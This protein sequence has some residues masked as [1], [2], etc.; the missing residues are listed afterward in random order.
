MKKFLMYVI[1]Y[2]LLAVFTAAAIFSPEG[3]GYTIEGAPWLPKLANIVG[4]ITT[5]LSIIMMLVGVISAAV[6]FGV[7]EFLPSSVI[8][9]VSKHGSVERAY[10]ELRFRPISFSIAVCFWA[11]LIGAGWIFT[12]VCWM[13]ASASI[14]VARHE[15][16]KVLKMCMDDNIE[17]PNF[18]ASVK[19]SREQLLRNINK[20]LESE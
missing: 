11:V 6:I 10:H 13:I 2:S 16:R 3:M 20:T 5:F 15:Q 7:K 8:T 18:E 9:N 17:I 14:H 4:N 12:A 19:E 1:S